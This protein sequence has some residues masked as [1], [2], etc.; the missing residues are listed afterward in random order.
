MEAKTYRALGGMSG[1]SLD[2]L[3]LALVDFRE[4]D[5]GWT[6]NLQRAQTCP[7]DQNIETLLRES[8]RMDDNGLREAHATF[9]KWMAAQ[10]TDFQKNQPVACLGIHGHTVFHEPAKGISFQLGDGEV[11]AR[12]TG[13]PTITDFR[14]RDIQAGGQGAPL[15]P[16]GEW[17]L[18]KEYD[19]FL[20]LGGIANASFRT[21]EGMV[22]GDIGPFNQVFNYFALKTGLAYDRWGVLSQT[23]SLVP[24]LF[25]SWEKIPFFGQAFPKSL[26]NQWVSTHF[27]TDLPHPPQDVL[28]T[29]SHFMAERVAGVVNARNP[30]QLLVTGGGAYHNFFMELLREKCR[31]NIVIPVPDIIEFK[32]AIVFAFL[33]LLRLLERPN[34][35]ASATGASHDTCGGALHLP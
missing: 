2:G 15:V 33:G 18:W 13:Q 34:A 10:I 21:D 35:M 30:G 4:T 23:G 6:F 22:A 11:I 26:A 32:E 12:A 20:N 14:T 5:N 16:L 28:H 31:S 9:G 29:F 19:G 8:V 1:S 7:F 25:S 27:L 3:D 24:E 17:H